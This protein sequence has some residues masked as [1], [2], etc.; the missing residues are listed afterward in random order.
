MAMSAMVYSSPAIN[1]LS[2]NR[3]SKHVQL[4]L[5]LHGVPIDFGVFKLFR[6]VG[7]KMTRNHHPGIGELPICQN[8]QDMA[9]VRLVGSRGRKALNFS[10]RYRRM[11]ADS[12][13]R[14]GGLVLWSIKAGILLLGFTST[15]TTAE[16][17]TAENV[18]QTRRHIQPRCGPT[19]RSSSSITVTFTPLGVANEY[20]WSGCLPTGNSFWWGCA[21]NGAIDAGKFTAIFLVPHPDLGWNVLII[22]HV[23]PLFVLRS[24]RL[25]AQA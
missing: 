15:K 18:A 19:S 6:R 1:G 21:G 7:V 4:S 14:V 12:K 13:T 24:K 20:S 25:A 3:R 8:S 10:A 2:A 5:D 23:V 22:A 11:D 9:S 17:V 16:L